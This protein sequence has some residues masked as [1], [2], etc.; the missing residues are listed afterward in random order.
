MV[1]DELKSSVAVA[2]VVIHFNTAIV[3]IVTCGLM[4]Q[5]FIE[6][7]VSFVAFVGTE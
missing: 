3:Q 4:M 5:L 2:A 7:I 6:S 1:T